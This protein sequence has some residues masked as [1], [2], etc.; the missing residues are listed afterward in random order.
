[1]KRRTGILTAVFTLVIVCIALTVTAYAKDLEP[2]YHCSSTGQFHCPSCNNTGVVTCDG[3]GGQGKSVCTGEAGKGPCDHGYYTCPNC[4]GKGYTQNYDENGNPTDTAPCGYQNCGG[5]GKQVCWTCHGSGWNNCTRC[6]GQGKAD[7]QNGNCKESRK[8]NWK[9]HY[10]MGAGYLLTNFWPGENDGVQNVP[11][12]G[13]KIWVN[14]K[15]TTYGGGS[16]GNSQTTPPSGG[17]GEPIAPPDDPISNESTVSLPENRN[18][19]FEI[20]ALPGVTAARAGAAVEI[21]RMSDEEQRYYAEL[22]EAEL[23]GILTNVQ[24]IVSTVQPGRC[25]EGMEDLLQTI[26]KRNGYESM[27]DARLLPIYFEGHQGIGF[28]VRVTVTLDQGVLAGGGDIYVYHQMSDGEIEP[29]GQAEYNTYEDG[30]VRQITFYTT[31]FSSFFTAASEL[32]LALEGEEDDLVLTTGVGEVQKDGISP[33]VWIA[34]AAAV[35]A[36][37]AV[38]VILVRKK[39]AQQD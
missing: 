16:S 35:L 14:G 30:S 13:D 18:S 31:G 10:C 3:C 32:D 1:M 11:V 21:R 5:T 37:G 8:V 23:T 20:P 29:L 27:E 6:N 39:K 4:M 2:C 34:V 26:A 36:A 25:E 15:S 12:N 24:Q 7:C 33:A 17:G 19:D 38:T 28:P 9:C 22:D